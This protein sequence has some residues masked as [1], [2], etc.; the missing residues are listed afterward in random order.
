MVRIEK[1][2]DRNFVL[3]RCKTGWN[4]FNWNVID[5]FFQ[6]FIHLSELGF[7]STKYSR[8]VN[9]SYVLPY[10]L[11]KIHHIFLYF[12]FNKLLFGYYI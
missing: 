10:F 2:M 8:T 1:S 4:S 7:D 5:D 6:N 3:D 12:Q 9:S 11:F